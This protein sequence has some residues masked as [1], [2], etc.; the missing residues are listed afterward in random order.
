MS[1]T[2]SHSPEALR[3]ARIEQLAGEVH[4]SKSRWVRG[5]CMVIGT[6][7]V[8]VG[9]PGLVLPLMPGTPLLLL[10][11]FFYSIG[12][13]RFFI[14]L[15]TNRWFGD[16]V[17]AWWHS[18][19]IPLHVKVKVSALLVT[20]FTVTILFLMPPILY[21]RIA[22]GAIGIGVLIYIWS[23]PNTQEALPEHVHPHTNAATNTVDE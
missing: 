15:L 11:A 10:A 1:N 23:H 4:L 20:S 6:I 3:Q 12:S 14:W 17:Y 9:V 22:I 5:A 7:L 21:A 13:Q 8:I 18:H 16:Y 19:G 2:D